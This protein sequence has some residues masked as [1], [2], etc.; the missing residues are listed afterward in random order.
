MVRWARRKAIWIAQN[1]PA[2]DVYFRGITAGARSLTALLAA[3]R[4]L[5]GTNSAPTW[6]R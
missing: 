2:A 5:V 3:S 1:K 6:S 4:C